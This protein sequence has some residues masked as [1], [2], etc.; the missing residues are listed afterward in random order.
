MEIGKEQAHLTAEIVGGEYRRVGAGAGAS[1]RVVGELARI[2]ERRATALRR[3]QC[4]RELLRPGLAIRKVVA[5]AV[6]RRIGNRSERRLRRLPEGDEV[7]AGIGQ[8]VSEDH[9]PLPGT[10]GPR[11]HG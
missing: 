8:T 7:I 1:D 9:E 5:A 6:I 2:R 10:V 3:V 4:A 11:R